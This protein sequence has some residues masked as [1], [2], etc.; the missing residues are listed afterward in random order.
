MNTVSTKR[1]GY[2][3]NPRNVYGPGCKYKQCEGCGEVIAPHHV[4]SMSELGRRFSTDN[5]GKAIRKWQK[6]QRKG[7]HG[8]QEASTA[9]RSQSQRP[10][11]GRASAPIVRPQPFEVMVPT[12]IV[13]LQEQ[14]MST[15]KCPIEGCA[16]QCPDNY[17]MCATHWR[18]VPRAMQMSVNR[19]WRTLLR[20]RVTEVGQEKYDLLR[21]AYDDARQAAIDLVQ[22]L[23][24]Q[25]IEQGKLSDVRQLDITQ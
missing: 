25:P 19:S 2:F 12:L 11:V 20:T 4:L 13:R 15:H 24:D 6:E 18:M 1:K 23:L 8:Q 9:G 22:S 14:I 10:K 7:S 5:I 17:L 3:I 16:K 21:K